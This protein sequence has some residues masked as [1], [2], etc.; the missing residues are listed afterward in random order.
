MLCTNL[1]SCINVEMTLN[2]NFTASNFIYHLQKGSDGTSILRN[3][4]E[5]TA[6]GLGCKGGGYK[7]NET[8]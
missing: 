3:A 2:N 6:E 5:R 1:I 7:R 4:L 8:L